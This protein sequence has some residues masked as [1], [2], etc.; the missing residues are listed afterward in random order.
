MSVSILKHGCVY[1]NRMIM[2][3]HNCDC[4]AVFKDIYEDTVKCPEC[5]CEND[6]QFLDDE[7]FKELK[8]EIKNELKEGK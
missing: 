6:I 7:D 1:K 3:C 8:D 2:R 4:I 5:F